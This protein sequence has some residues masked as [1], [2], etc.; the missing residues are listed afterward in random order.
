M[1]TGFWRSGRERGL[2]ASP[3]S[4]PDPSMRFLA[5]FSDYTS[6]RSQFVP[7][8]VPEGRFV[9]FGPSDGC[10]LRASGVLPIPLMVALIR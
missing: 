4:L 1:V 2:T 6:R 9:G 7:L 3:F 8:C 10:G 5:E